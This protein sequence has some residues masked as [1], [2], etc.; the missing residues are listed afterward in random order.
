[1]SSKDKIQEKL[2]AS[3]RKTKQNTDESKSVE[4]KSV[5][6]KKQTS[7]AKRKVT[8]KNRTGAKKQKASPAKMTGFQS[9]TRV[10]PD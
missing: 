2:M 3:I 9:P 1:M 10:W 6:K 5:T 4:Y 8:K 7:T